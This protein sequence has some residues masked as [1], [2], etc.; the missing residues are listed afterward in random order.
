M[1]VRTTNVKPPLAIM[2][3]FPSLY[4]HETPGPSF[5]NVL[6]LKIYGGPF[7]II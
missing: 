2:L 5:Q 6:K 1:S 3:D 4:A 7:F